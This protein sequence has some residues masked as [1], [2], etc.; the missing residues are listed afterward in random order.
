MVTAVTVSCVHLKLYHF[1]WKEAL[2]L[3]IFNCSVSYL[4]TVPFYRLSEFYNGARRNKIFFPLMNRFWID[5]LACPPPP[6]THRPFSLNGGKGSIKLRNNC[7]LV[8]VLA[9]LISINHAVTLI[10]LSVVWVI[11][12][13]NKVLFLS[14]CMFGEGR[15]LSVCE[16]M[17]VGWLVV[18][19]CLLFFVFFI[20]VL[21]SMNYWEASHSKGW[22]GWRRRAL[23]FSVVWTLFGMKK[24]TQF[25]ALGS[26]NIRGF[27]KGNQRAPLRRIKA[28]GDCSLQSKSLEKGDD[29]Q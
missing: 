16:H 28:R 17:F 5:S 1:L 9:S 25:Q 19:F 26:V 29:F 24:E 12:T 18:F 22:W 4:I 10:S 27:W 20:G 6:H 8:A 3:E 14:I 2:L 15:V 7:S 13:W 11:S 23:C 21:P